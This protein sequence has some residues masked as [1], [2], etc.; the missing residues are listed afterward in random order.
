MEPA[1]LRFGGGVSE[2]MMHPLVA[3]WM[4]VVFVLI[5]TLPRN[6]VIV[7][8]LFTFFSVP[9][10]QVVVL[11]GLHFTALRILIIAG[12]IRR[13]STGASPSAGKYPGGFNALDKV[14]VLWTI[15][16]LVVICLQWMNWQ[17]T[18]A[19]LGDFLDSYGGYLVARY[20]IPDEDAVRRTVKALA[21]V[22]IVQGALM[23][24][25]QIMHQNLYGYLGGWPIAVTYRDGHIRSQGVMGNISGGVFGGALVPMFLWLLTQKKS[26][27]MALLAIAGSITM[28]FT[29]DAST[30]ILALAASVLGLAFW[31][32]RKQ[33]RAIRW[34][35]SLTLIGLHLVMNAPV[36]SLIARID[37]TGSSSG[38][39]RY[40][41]VNNCI[42]H[43]SM[44]WLL[45]TK[46]YNTW[47]WD[48]FD[49]CNQ[50]VVCAVTGGLATLVLFIMIYSR[51][52]GA[53]GTARKIVSGDRKQE[54]FL[55]CLGSTIFAHVV[56]SFGINYMALL[57][58]AL[59]PLFAF[60]S[61]IAFEANKKMPARN[62]KTLQIPRIGAQ[63]YLPPLS[64]AK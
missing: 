49:L 46:Y 40:Y 23:M 39:H 29:S 64:E 50:F 25:E 53:I 54:W 48:M 9:I 37:L 14:I 38:Y 24:N 27:R 57:Q 21:V 36:W 33:M 32:L 6:K 13:A 41:L 56:A 55:W 58:M 47:G 44:W 7:P 20:F 42:N 15:S 51:S 43:F 63:G 10:G 12:L 45:G 52:F 5:L 1:H 62:L 22:C 30:S 3:L 59:F 34:A 11:G 61:V 35:L 18:V 26:R 16:T 8:L 60:V 17:A 31:F 28:V 4:L 19:N 2:T